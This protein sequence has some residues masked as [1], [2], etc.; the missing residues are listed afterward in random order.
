MQQR[1][2]SS[3]ATD[4][5]ALL[6]SHERYD[7]Y[8]DDARDSGAFEDESLSSQRVSHPALYA[9]R[10]AGL[11]E[12]LDIQEVGEDDFSM[13]MSLALAELMLGCCVHLFIYPL[14]F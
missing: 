6:T 8:G 13:F 5:A 12:G 11:R 2:G 3:Q 4:E 1:H 9:R 7:S 14:S 10:N